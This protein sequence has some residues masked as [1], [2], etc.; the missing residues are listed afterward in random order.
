MARSLPPSQY[1]AYSIVS[2]KQNGKK[3]LVCLPRNIAPEVKPRTPRP[4][5]AAGIRYRHRAIF[6]GS[7]E[8]DLRQP[9]ALTP[10]PPGLQPAGPAAFAGDDLRYRSGCLL[11]IAHNSAQDATCATPAP[12]RT[13][14]P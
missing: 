10:A 14:W 3:P 11:L 9:A 4:L 5:A 7:S 8:R 6:Q 1:R 12:A 2:P 13:A